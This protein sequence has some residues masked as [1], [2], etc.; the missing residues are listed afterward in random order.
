MEAIVQESIMKM[1]Q[2][3]K[4]ADACHENRQKLLDVAFWVKPATIKYDYECKVR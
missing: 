4:V 2:R 3:R 1:R